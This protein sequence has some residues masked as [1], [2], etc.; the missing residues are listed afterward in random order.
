MGDVRKLL[1]AVYATKIAVE[2]TDSE[3]KSLALAFLSQRY[4]EE[5]LAGIIGC[6]YN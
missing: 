2:L 4:T 5:K 1:R 3:K 6:S